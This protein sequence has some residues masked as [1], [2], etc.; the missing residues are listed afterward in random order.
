MSPFSKLGCALLV[1]SLA[2]AAQAQ[3]PFDSFKQFSA[4]MVT[5]GAP[6]H[7]PQGKGAMKVYRSG[8][9]MRVDMVGGAGYMI[10]ELAQGTTY[11]VMGNGMCMQMTRQGEQNPFAAAENAQIERAS[12]GS[13]TVDG[14]ACRVENVTVTP[15]NGEPTKMKVW[16]AQDLKGFPIKV[17]LQSSH[18]PM[19]VEYRN[20]SF[21][22]PDASMFVH[23]ENCRQV[24]MMPS[25]VPR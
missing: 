14:H 7:G 18:G 13:D 15:Q 17:E 4:T 23:P 21:N 10:T 9:N 3:N 16:E 11:M 2:A 24:P 25:G 5:T 8:N 12:A 19:T 6:A 22:Q 20:V 1:S